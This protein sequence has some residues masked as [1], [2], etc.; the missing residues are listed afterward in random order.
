MHSQESCCRQ[1][2]TFHSDYWVLVLNNLLTCM[3]NIRLV[4][5]THFWS[6][7]TFAIG[8]RNAIQNTDY[9]EDAHTFQVLR[10]CHYSTRTHVHAGAASCVHL[11]VCLSI[12]WGL[13]PL[14]ESKYFQSWW[15]CITSRPALVQKDGV[16]WLYMYA[17]MHAHMYN[18][19]TNHISLNKKNLI[20][21]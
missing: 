17:H 4:Y 21:M 1:S 3:G 10:L 14:S 11:F 19:S 5:K 9:N 13:G 6:F 18:Q 7:N 20:V 12:H 16:H 2:L 8:N 15:L